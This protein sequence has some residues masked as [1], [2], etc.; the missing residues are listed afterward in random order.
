MAADTEPAGFLAGK[1]L[2]KSRPLLR[3]EIYAIK[4]RGYTISWLSID[5]PPNRVRRGA[6]NHSAAS[7]NARAITDLMWGFS[8]IAGVGFL[9]V[10]GRPLFAIIRFRQK[11]GD[12]L[13]KTALPRQ[14]E[15]NRF[16][17]LAWT[18]VP[19]LLLL[20]IFVFTGR[21]FGPSQAGLRS[22][23]LTPR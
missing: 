20:V 5:L 15:G 4:S 13:D 22:S 7:T 11:G 9:L 17:E 12:R 8:A 14:V 6:L 10:E 23:R 21:R 18:I 19:A 2:T 3:K 16:L 1:H